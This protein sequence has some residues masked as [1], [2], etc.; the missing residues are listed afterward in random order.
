MK[1]QRCNRLNLSYSF[2][3]VPWYILIV[4]L[5]A[6]LLLIERCEVSLQRQPLPSCHQT[7]T[8]SLRKGVRWTYGR[9]KIRIYQCRTSMQYKNHLYALSLLRPCFCFISFIEYL[10]KIM[11][12]NTESLIR[13]QNA[14]LHV[15]PKPRGVSAW[16]YLY[17][18]HT[19]CSVLKKCLCITI[20]EL[21]ARVN[22]NMTML[23][24]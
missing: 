13:I 24:N 17:V 10:T 18:S 23:K 8:P 20:E 14:H 15:L 21:G 5:V 11:L 19:H 4:T 2:P 3:D 12:I 16:I 22:E 1:D 9:N 6:V 7:N